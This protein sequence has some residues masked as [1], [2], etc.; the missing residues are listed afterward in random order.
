[1]MAVKTSLKHYVVQQHIIYSG[2][3][4][5]DVIIDT[6]LPLN[7]IDVTRL[8]L[9]L[10]N[11]GQD[12]PKMPF[13]RMLD[14]LVDES[15]IDPLICVGIYCGEN[16]KMEYGVAAT[17]DYKGLG[18]SAGSYQQFIMDEMLPFVQQ[19]YNIPSFKNKSFAGFSLG[20]LS[21]LDIVW[22]NPALFKACGVFSGAL[23][24]R[25]KAY[26]EGYNDA[27]DRIMHQQIKKG[28]YHSQLR[29]FFECGAMDETEDR[30]NNGIIDTIDD[31]IDLIDELYKLG[32]PKKA[33]KYLEIEDGRHDVP[34]WAKAFPYFLQWQ[35]GKQ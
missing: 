3:L 21:A 29:F 23:W 19:T 9:L 27:T 20:A 16:R 32:Y 1:M 30:N 35:W 2:F 33:V 12:L 6:Y 5:R 28:T 4:K 34:T 8:D 22:N 14:K 15:I 10:I 13:D 18:A 25:S 31:T 11:D 7:I 24:W 26:D 17:P